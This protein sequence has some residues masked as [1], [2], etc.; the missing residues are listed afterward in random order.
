MISAL[1]DLWVVHLWVPC[2]SLSTRVSA[3]VIEFIFLA[4]GSLP[5]LQLQAL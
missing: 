4:S 3:V 1:L 2:Q 5:D